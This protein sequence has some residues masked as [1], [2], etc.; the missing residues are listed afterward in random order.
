MAKNSNSNGSVLNT[1]DKPYNPKPSRLS[2]KAKDALW[3]YFFIAPVLIGLIIFYIIPFVQNIYFSLCEVDRFNRASFMGLDN[4]IEMFS[5]E[6]LYR[7]T[8]N[9]FIYVLLTVPLGVFLAILIAVLLNQRIGGQTIYRT[10]YYLP[11][12][13]MP[14]AI[15]MVWKWMYNGDYG[16]INQILKSLGLSGK[17]WLNDPDTSLAAIAVVGI[18][19]MVGYNMVILLAGLQGI[20]KHYYEAAALDGANG[21]QQFFHITIPILSPS[22]FFVLITSL[23]S[24]FQVFDII[25]M[26]VPR[27]SIA[28]DA[29][30]SLIVLFY[31]N[32]FTYGNKG[33]ASA[34]SIFTF[35]I[36]LIFTIVQLRLQKR[37]VIY[38]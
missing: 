5:T 16:V 23:I 38:E 12:I 25:Y 19:M 18:W 9:T 22:I 8:A 2:E 29:S 6:E 11:A 10:L 31:R 37:W 35:A 32:A 17:N 7:A 3:G 28:S 14:A 20:P 26:M 4:Y 1:A 21:R 13:T 24:G 33:F 30:E 27:T 36:I 15:S 34:I